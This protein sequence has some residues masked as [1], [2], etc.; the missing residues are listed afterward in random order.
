MVTWFNNVNIIVI[1]LQVVTACPTF[2]TILEGSRT[3][4]HSDLDTI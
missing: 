2:Q 4:L 1:K 3:A